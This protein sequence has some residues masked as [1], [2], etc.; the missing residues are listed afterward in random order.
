[1]AAI[2]LTVCISYSTFWNACGQLIKVEYT[3]FAEC[4]ETLT[5]MKTQPKFSY[6][7]CAPKRM[8]P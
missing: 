4:H 8:T 1:M 5:E 6:G 2:I 3:T 7:F